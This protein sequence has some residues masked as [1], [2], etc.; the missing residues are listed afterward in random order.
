MSAVELQV[1][2]DAHDPARLAA[3]WAEALR[4]RVQPPPAGF[5]TWDDALDAWGV[6]PE[7]RNSRSAVV[8]REGAART[9]AHEAE[10]ARLAELGATVVR[11]VPA[12]PSTGD[13]DFVVMADPEGN[14][15]CVD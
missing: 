8:P 5:D 7:A 3:F 9:T 6:P 11:R 13:A 1:T 4:Y 15:F 12:S 14:E 10:V 2:I